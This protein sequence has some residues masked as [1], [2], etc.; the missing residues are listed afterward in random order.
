MSRLRNA[1]KLVSFFL[2][3]CLFYIITQ[4]R[5][6]AASC[7]H[8]AGVR[9]CGDCG[10]LVDEDFNPS[11]VMTAGY[12]HCPPGSYWAGLSGGFEFL[13]DDCMWARPE[14]IRIYG[15]VR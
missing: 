15:R 2:G 11:Q 1:L 4:P 5:R 9:N 13:C 7:R 14:Y 8:K 3:V 6:W 10:K 12:Y